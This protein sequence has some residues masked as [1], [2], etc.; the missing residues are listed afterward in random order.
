MCFVQKNL[1]PALFSF[2]VSQFG[3]LFSV[4][5]VQKLKI[6]TTRTMDGT[7]TFSQKKMDGTGTNEN[8]NEL[9]NGTERPPNR[10]ATRGDPPSMFSKDQA[11]IGHKAEPAK[12]H[13]R[14]R[15]KSTSASPLARH[16]IQKRD[17]IFR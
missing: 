13:V 4:H 17:L 9:G 7:G 11:A 8:R 14:S 5:I 15:E 10:A 2:S 6:A 3:N 12:K 1:S 16:L